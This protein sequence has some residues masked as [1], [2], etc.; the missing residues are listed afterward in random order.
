MKRRP[1]ASSM[2]WKLPASARR[3]IVNSL[4]PAA[5]AASLVHR[6]HPHRAA[7]LAPRDPPVA[8]APQDQSPFGFDGELHDALQ[9]FH[10]KSSAISYEL[11]NLALN[12]A[13]RLCLLWS[14]LLRQSAHTAL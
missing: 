3:Q 11:E 5:R 2:K 10:K 8:P 7:P 9:L 13:I 1:A 14:S 6:R 4:T 12:V